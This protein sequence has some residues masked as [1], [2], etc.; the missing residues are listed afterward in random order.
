MA[1]VGRPRTFDRDEALRKAMLLFWE[2]GYEGTTMA[3]LIEAIGM[4]APSVYAAFGN[5][6]KLFTE[7][8]QLYAGI[9]NDGPLKTLKEDPDVYE[10]FKNLFKENIRLFTNTDNP[11]SC[12]I[13]TAAINCAPE[14]NEH[15]ETLKGMRNAYKDAFERRLKQAITDQQLSEEADAISLAEFYTTFAHGLALRARDGASKKELETSSEFALLA[16]KSK[17]RMGNTFTQE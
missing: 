17:L 7:A 4:K 9:V 12:L 16:L 11:T 15:V 2:K 3:N 13:M 1:S 14:H 5:K 8:V 10:A 6:D